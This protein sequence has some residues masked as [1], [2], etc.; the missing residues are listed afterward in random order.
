MLRP[1][2]GLLALAAALAA[3]D[4]TPALDVDVPEHEAAVV[5]RTVLA[6][7]STPV[8]R[9][10][11]SQD[12]YGRRRYGAPVETPAA[13]VTLVRDGRAEPLTLRSESCPFYDRG[14]ETS[15]ECGAYVG[16][17]PV[18]P[19]ATYTVRAEVEGL[20]AAEGTVTVPPR[21]AVAVEE[22]TEGGG[23]RRFRVRLEDPPGEG[24]RY[25]LELLSRRQGFRSTTC[26]ETG[27]RDSTSFFE[28]DGWTRFSFETSNPVLL[29]A[30]REVPGDGVEFV[31]FTD[32]T[33]DGAAF[34]ASIDADPQGRYVREVTDGP[35]MVRVA[36]LAPVVYDA[37]QV[38][39]FSLGDDNPFAEP[40]DLPSNVE[41]G[42]GVVG[43]VTLVEVAFPGR[44]GAAGAGR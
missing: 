25:A 7:D 22:A 5:L 13:R 18:E 40:A 43:A 17:T 11:V 42:Y 6:A 20:P 33:F 26:D 41:G 24:G 44:G 34:A 9:V 23:A 35:L 30:S 29:S 31:A 27:C 3:C 10:S 4:F 39:R 16:A 38:A 12:P 14:V 37:Y 2:A 32:Q 1:L 15:T 28:T 36:A 8:V 19:G 21:P